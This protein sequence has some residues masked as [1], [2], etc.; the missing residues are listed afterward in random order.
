[1]FNKD[2]KNEFPLGSRQ[3]PVVK[4]VSSSQAGLQAVKFRKGGTA[5]PA[6]KK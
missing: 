4:K 1:M 6:K 3:N 2:K 5:K